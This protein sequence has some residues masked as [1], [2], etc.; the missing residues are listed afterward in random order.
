MSQLVGSLAGAGAT[1][2]AYPRL[3]GTMQASTRPR[4][5]VAGDCMGR[6]TPSFSELEAEQCQ[7]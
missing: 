7:G 6:A 5:S 2:V 1:L 4:N 3:K